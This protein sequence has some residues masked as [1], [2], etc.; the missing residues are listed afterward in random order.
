MI[1]RHEVRPGA[2]DRSYGVQ[3]A[4]LAGLPRAVI[5]R[6]RTVLD[7]LEKGDRE[8]SSPKAMI[9]DLPLFSAAVSA[10][11]PVAKGASPL[12]QR[13]KD[14]HPDDLS[15]RE[16]LQILYDLKALSTPD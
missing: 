7:A 4:Q 15:P 13:L 3:V 1:F 12:E 8:A 9:E 6:A 2:A 11:P 5:E 10:A 14:L 16:A